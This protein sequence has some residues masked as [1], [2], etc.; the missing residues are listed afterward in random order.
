MKNN[1]VYIICDNEGTIHGASLDYNKAQ[2]LK[3]K[4]QEKLDQ[5]NYTEDIQKL[6]EENGSPN[7]R[8]RKLYA[9]GRASRGLPAHETRQAS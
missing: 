2:K 6:Y 7:S 9:D 3:K 4:A 1:L 5:E 8:L